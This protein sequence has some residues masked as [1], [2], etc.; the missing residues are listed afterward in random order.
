M[1]SN[2]RSG[3]ARRRA[4]RRSTAS[5][6]KTTLGSKRGNLP[7]GTCSPDA[8]VEAPGPVTHG[9]QRVT[10]RVTAQRRVVAADF[11]YE[12]RPVRF[13]PPPPRSLRSVYSSFPSMGEGSEDGGAAKPCTPPPPL[14]GREVWGGGISTP[15]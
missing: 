3:G 10:G 4:G 8:P 13:R 1:R 6:T 11:P 2:R 9:H 5:V 7:G 12:N 15:R 14:M